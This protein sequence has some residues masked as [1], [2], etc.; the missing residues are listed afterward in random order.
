M[1]ND[2]ELNIRTPKN[3]LM[4]WLS[5]LTAPDLPSKLYQCADIMIIRLWVNLNLENWITLEEIV[6]VFL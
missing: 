1:S 3:L 4:Y 6:V 5:M 2:E